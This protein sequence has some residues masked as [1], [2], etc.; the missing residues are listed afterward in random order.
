LLLAPKS[1]IGAWL[2]VL[3]TN[4]P[5]QPSDYARACEV[6]DEIG[7]IQVG[8][9]QAI[10][11]GDEPDRTTLVRQSGNEVFILRWRWAASEQS[12]LS[13]LFFSL[14][15]N[16]IPFRP[17]GTFLARTAEY[18]LFDSAS[19][20]LDVASSLSVAFRAGIYELGTA[21]FK[22]DGSTFALV[23]R[24]LAAPRAAGSPSETTGV[25]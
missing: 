8:E 13:A 21:M 23:H 15:R 2:G 24:L 7:V 4:S 14:G 5:G 19:P 16:A 20:G 10:V 1:S 18:L 25:K 11:L 22:P 9:D 12:L 3:P 6:Q 17:A